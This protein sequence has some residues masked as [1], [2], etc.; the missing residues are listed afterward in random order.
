MVPLEHW[1]FD[2]WVAESEDQFGIY[3]SSPFS[4]ATP[5]RFET[6][7]AGE[8]AAVIIQFEPTTQPI[9]FMRRESH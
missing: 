2:A 3:E 6:G 1:H 7:A 5:L 4:R 8:I 9:R